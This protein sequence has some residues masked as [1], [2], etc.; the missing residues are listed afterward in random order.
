M[1]T[2]HY[3]GK[4]HVF[5]LVKSHMIFAGTGTGGEGEGEWLAGSR[6]AYLW[7]NES[8]CSFVP[9]CEKRSFAR[10][11]SL[12]GRQR[13]I[14]VQ[15][16]ISPT[17]PFATIFCCIGKINFGRTTSLHIDK[18]PRPDFKLIK[19]T[20]KPPVHRVNKHGHHRPKE[21]ESYT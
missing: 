11:A 16:K 18:R 5:C 20:G 19:P 7:V 6:W 14:G 21:H 1:A 17:L 13:V 3:I 15:R 2:D 4:L 12:R 9:R 10:V 8:V